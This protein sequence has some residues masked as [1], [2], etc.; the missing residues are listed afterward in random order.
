MAFFRKI[1]VDE[2]EYEWKF[3]F[4]DYDWQQSSHLIFRA[5][6]KTLK[7]I[8]F[9]TSETNGIGKC[10]FNTGVDAIKN[11]QP[12]TINLNQPRFIEEL[13][14]YLFASR[15]ESSAKGMLRFNDGIEILRVLGYQFEYRLEH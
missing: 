6:D 3:S 14:H 9:F 13:L 2:K 7:I 4:D 1:I 5:L 10:P 11:G 12:V 15:L 8:L